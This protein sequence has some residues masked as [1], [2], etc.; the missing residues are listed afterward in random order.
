VVLG[1]G[2]QLG[3][4]LRRVAPSG[5]E[6]VALT[7]AEADLAEPTAAAAAVVAARPDVVL[8]AAAYTAVDQAERE[9]ELALAVNAHAVEAIARAAD[10]AGARLVHVS[11][12]Y[13]FDGAAHEPYPPDAPV[14]PLGVYGRTKLA[15]ERAALDVLGARAT[16]V[17]TAWVYAAC[18]RNFVHTMLRLMRER[19]EVRVVD[20]QLGTPTW[21]R[22]LA[23]ACWRAAADPGVHG[24]HHWTDAGVASWYD[25]AV[26][27][28]EEALALGLLARAVPVRP[29]RTADYPTPARRPSYAVLDRTG[30]WAALGAAAHWRVNLRHMLAE[31][32]R[33]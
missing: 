18:G 13:V 23:G 28:Q 32:P 5:W 14:A 26:A 27:I 16:V 22:A 24:V 19:D 7:R 3:T 8:N 12:D 21:A 4:E 30:G 11:T 10:A 1:A 15:G 31:L 33:A 20:D 2:G 25:F 17:R 9:P 6:V 29:I